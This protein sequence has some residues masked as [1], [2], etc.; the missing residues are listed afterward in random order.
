[1]DGFAY[2]TDAN[3]I[4]QT[5]MA[6]LNDLDVLIV[7]AL[8]REPHPTHFNF[9][10]ALEVVERLKPKRVYFTHLTHTTLHAAVEAELPPHVRLAYDGLILELR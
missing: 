4:P 8:R 10:Q 1:V 5:S 2:V 9:D 6:L 3:F 7:D